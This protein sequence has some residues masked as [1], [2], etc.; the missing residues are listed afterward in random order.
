MSVVVK[1]TSSEP[2]L[3]PGDAPR[4]EIDL[5]LVALAGGDDDVVIDLVALEEAV[6]EAV[7]QDRREGR[8]SRWRNG[9]ITAAFREVGHEIPSFDSDYWSD[10]AVVP[11]ECLIAE[12]P[13]RKGRFRGLRR[14]RR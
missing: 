1:E 7:E 13:P 8:I 10:V 14:R 11:H 4:L 12:H 6:E 2:G 9:G 5:D 3:V